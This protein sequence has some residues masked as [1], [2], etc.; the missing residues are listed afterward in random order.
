M[1]S[2][3][4]N[5]TT[6]HSVQENT[7]SNT[8]QEHT[9][10]F[11]VSLTTPL[12]ENMWFSKRYVMLYVATMER[13]NKYNCETEVKP[14]SKIYIIQLKYTFCIIDVWYWDVNI[15]MYEVC[16]VCNV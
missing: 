14:F 4:T 12:D 8:K 10:C 1:Y 7:W 15:E 5:P 13:P 3:V 16:D 6:P 9:F 11:E 2:I